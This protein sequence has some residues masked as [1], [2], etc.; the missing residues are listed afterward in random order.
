[1]N[2]ST[3]LVIGRFQP[4]HRGHLELMRAAEAKADQ[5]LIILGSANGA[6]NLRNPF[7]PAEREE[8]IRAALKEAGLKK[9]VQFRGVRDYFYNDAGWINEVR[10][11]VLSVS[12]GGPVVLAGYTKDFS[13][14]YLT[15]FSDWERL[16]VASDQALHATSTREAYFR[17]ANATLRSSKEL[18]SSSITWLARFAQTEPYRDLHEEQ[19]YADKYKASWASA[20]FPPVFV[21]ADAVVH[22]CG[23]LLLIQRKHNPGRGLWANPGGFLD[24]H[25]RIA[26]AAIRE[27]FEETQIDVPADELRTACTKVQVFDHPLRSSRGRTITHAHLFELKRKQLPRFKASDD[28][29]AARWIPMLDLGKME[30]QFF[31]DHFHMIHALL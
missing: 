4:L 3:A 31:E 24:P 7:R 29:A 21:T 18:T 26:D 14:S 25:E 11:N 28:A 27:L 15:W 23:H 5:L 13:S 10:E 2:L 20:P 8:M 9:P 12:A 16:E 6:R 22:C 19:L 17:D 1:M 30:E